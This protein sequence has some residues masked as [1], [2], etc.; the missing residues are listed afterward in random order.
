MQANQIAP[1]AKTNA[2]PY[3]NIYIYIYIYI[4]IIYIYIYIYIY[5]ILYY[6]I[7]IYIFRKFKLGLFHNK[8][9]EI[10]QV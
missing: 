3:N 5:I 8:A 1:F 10:N 4:Y 6:I 2:L 7:Y 9:Y